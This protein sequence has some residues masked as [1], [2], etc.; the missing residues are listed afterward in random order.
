M[1]VAG[2]SALDLEAL[3]SLPHGT[4]NRVAVELEQG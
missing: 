2:K 1:Y 4:D 3:E